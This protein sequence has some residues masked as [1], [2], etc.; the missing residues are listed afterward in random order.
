M[1]LTKFEQSGFIL[2][3]ENGFRLAFDI[4]NKTPIEK[5]S[6]VTV[7]AML[8]SHI[9][10]D[11]FSL[12]Q[13]KALNPKNLY[14]NTECIETL[15]EEVLNSE[16]VQVKVGD[17][18]TM[19]TIKVQL[20]NVDHGPNVSAPLKENFGFLITADNKTVYFA[21]D[22]FYESGIDVTNL[23]VDIALLPVGTFYTFGPQEASDFAKKF[24]RIGKV[25]PMHYEKT[26]ET[27][28][29]FI[30]LAVAEG[31]NTDSYIL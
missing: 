29:Q 12:D 14:L 11:H 3:T 20:F 6:G 31:L 26:P 17:E 10:G 2:E 13:I 28:E 5:L 30:K 16:I 15:G 7:D 18:I 27:R 24:K 23:E 19:D 8:V 21:G 25:V 1:K 9:H 22:I 4:G